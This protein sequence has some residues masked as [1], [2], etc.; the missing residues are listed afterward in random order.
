[1]SEDTRRVLELLA[2]G[3][4]TVEEAER[5]LRAL[6]AEPADMGELAVDVDQGKAQVRITCE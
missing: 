4:V 5:L 3:K 2:S 6:G 1:M